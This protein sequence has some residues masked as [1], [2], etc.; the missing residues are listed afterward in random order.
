MEV[1]QDLANSR[2]H[3]WTPRPTAHDNSDES[4]KMSDDTNSPIAL[5]EFIATPRGGTP[6]PAKIVCTVIDLTA[7]YTQ[8]GIKGFTKN[9]QNYALRWTSDLSMLPGVE[10]YDH[11]TNKDRG[12]ISIASNTLYQHKTLQLTHTTYDMQ[13]DKDRIRQSRYHGIMVLS[14]DTEHPYLYGQVLDLF[15]IKVENNAPYTILHNGKDATLHMVWVC[16]FKLDNAQG[17]SGF[18]TLRYPSVSF[19]R[20]DEPDAFGLIHP[21]EIIRAVHLI[22]RFKFGHTEEYLSGNSRGRPETEKD[23]WRHFNINM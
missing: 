11:F 3:G 23:D 18:H 12:H 15:H 13:E 5:A 1:L 2:T 22:P 10:S 4:Y 19:C 16:W 14:D 8:C 6:D 21:D 17:Q 7:N 9:L 20:S